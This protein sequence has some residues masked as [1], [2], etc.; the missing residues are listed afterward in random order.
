MEGQTSPAHPSKEDNCDGIRQHLNSCAA[1]KDRGLLLDFVL[2]LH[3][4]GIKKGDDLK[5]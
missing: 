4:T 1:F 2:A 5:P 3:C